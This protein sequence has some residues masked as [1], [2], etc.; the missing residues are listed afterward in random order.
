MAAAADDVPVMRADPPIH[1]SE[2]SQAGNAPGAVL[3]RDTAQHGRGPVTVPGF[4]GS[5]RDLRLSPPGARNAL[6]SESPG[7]RA[8]VDINE[9]ERA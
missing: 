4:S 6:T 9:E 1:E 3:V 7:Q 5:S 8:A 2:E